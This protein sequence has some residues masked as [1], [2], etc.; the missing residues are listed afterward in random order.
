M[1]TVHDVEQYLKD[2]AVP[3]QD[4]G[5]GLFVVRDDASG[6]H[7]LA[8]KVEAPLVL[9][10]LRVMDLPPTGARE[11]LFEELLRLNG[12]GLLHS[13]FCLQ[14]EAVYLTATL[15]LEN[16]D[17]NELQAVMDDISIAVSQHVPRLHSFNVI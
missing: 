12:G 15:P 8:V 16:L 7:D 5:D 14:N 1:R 11:K 4:L 6:L 17:L 3:Y 13:A 10:R 9:F 2:S